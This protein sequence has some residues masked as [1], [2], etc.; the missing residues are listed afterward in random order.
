LPKETTSTA[1]L[2]L[3]RGHGRHRSRSRTDV[4]H[5]SAVREETM[6][7]VIFATIALAAT[8]YIVAPSWM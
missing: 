4:F 3:Y 1:T 7:H 5:P 2:A 8:L 6:K